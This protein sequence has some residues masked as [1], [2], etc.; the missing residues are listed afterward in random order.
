MKPRLSIHHLSLFLAL[1]IS[2]FLLS[3]LPSNASAAAKETENRKKIKILENTSIKSNGL[4]S[5]LVRTGEKSIVFKGKFE[6]EDPTEKIT[7]NWFSANQKQFKPW[8]K[9]TFKTESPKI[10]K[11][12]ELYINGNFEKLTKALFDKQEGEDLKAEA[13]D[14]SPAESGS[15]G[16]D[17]SADASSSIGSESGSQSQQTPG[18]PATNPAPTTTVDRT[19]SSTATES[20]PHEIAGSQ[21][22]LKTK[23][24]TTFSDGSTEE[25]AC[26]TASTYDLLNTYEGCSPRH[27]FVS[28][29]T[30][31]QQKT[32]YVNDE[33]NFIMTRSCHD[34]GT[35]FVHRKSAASC[36]ETFDKTN[37]LIYQSKKTYYT[38]INA[39]V[40]FISEC[41]M[42]ANDFRSVSPEDYLP[43]YS[44]ADRV[45][46]ASSLA[47]K[48][49]KYYIQLGDKKVYVSD[50]QDDLTSPMP[51]YRDYNNCTYFHDINA[52][53]SSRQYQ[54]VYDRDG[55]K[56]SVSG[57][58]P[59]PN[60]SFAHITDE[61]FCTPDVINRQLYKK[62]S[63]Y[64]LD[65]TGKRVVVADCS[66][67]DEIQT[68]DPAFV[69]KNYS[70]CDP[71]VDLSQMRAV[72]RFVEE[73]SLGTQ[74]KEISTCIADPSVTYPIANSAAGCAYRIDT[75]GGLAVMQERLFFNDGAEDHFV[76]ECRDSAITAP[77]I[78]SSSSCIPQVSG[79]NLVEY[80]ETYYINAN[81]DKK[82][83][84]A[85]SASD[86]L[87]PI[88][89][90]MKTYDY[91]SCTDSIDLTAMKAF[92]RYKT[93]V[94]I[95]GNQTLLKSCTVDSASAYTITQ[96]DV[97]CGIRHDF[98]A[99]VSYVQN[100]LYYTNSSGSD[101]DV[102][103]CFDTPKTYTHYK[104]V[105]NCSP[106]YDRETNV[107][108]DTKKTYFTDDNGNVNHITG[109]LM[110]MSSSKAVLSSDI[111][112][113]YQSEDEVDFE[114]RAAYK[115]YREYIVLSGDKKEYISAV[116]ADKASPMPIEKD[117]GSCDFY[118]DQVGRQSFRQFEEV[119]IRDGV[120]KVVSDC[121]KDNARV[122]AHITDGQYCIPKIQSKIVYTRESTYFLDETSKRIVV[123]ECELNGATETI[124][125]SL[126]EKDYLICAP[127]IDLQAGVAHAA[128]KE[129]VTFDETDK[130]LSDCIEDQQRSYIITE[131]D[132]G[133]TYRVDLGAEKA[134][135]QKRLFYNNGLEDVYLTACRDSA[136]E[137]A[138]VKSTAL[139]SPTITDDGSS[140]N[141][142][143]ET[144]FID[145][146]GVKRTV[147]ECS[148][149]GVSYL[150][151]EDSKTKDF[152]RCEPDI[153]VDEMAAYGRYELF[154]KAGGENV[155]IQDC[156]VDPSVIYA[157]D[158]DYASC[159]VKIDRVSAT[160]IQYKKL[161]YRKGN[162]DVYVSACI[163]SDTA[164]PIQQTV[165]GC[166][167]RI[168]MANLTATA[169]KRDYYDSGGS[170][171]YTTEC[172]DTT[173]ATPILQSAE[174]CPVELSADGL[175]LIEKKESYYINADGHKK[176]V[177]AC[178]PT[179]TVT[180]VPEE[181]KIRNY[182]NCDPI[183]DM[184]NSRANLQYQLY[185]HHGN[186]EI[187]IQGCT[188][189]L[190]TDY[191]LFLDYSEC[192]PR[193]D[194]VNDEV[195]ETAKWY[196]KDGLD[197]VY[198]TKCIESETRYPIESRTDVCEVLAIDNDPD[199]VIQQSRLFY[200][201]SQGQLKYITPC[202]PTGNVLAVTQPVCSDIQTAGSARY[203]HNYPA[204][205][206]YIAVKDMYGEQVIQNCHMSDKHNAMTHYQES[207]GWA[208][209][210][211]RFRS[212]LKVRT[213]ITDALTGAKVY[214]DSCHTS[215]TYVSYAYMGLTNIAGNNGGS[216]TCGAGLYWDGSFPSG[217]YCY[218]YDNGWKYD[219]FA[220]NIDQFNAT[221]S[222]SQ[223]KSGGYVGVFNHYL[224]PD[225]TSYH[226]WKS[227]YCGIRSAEIIAAVPLHLP[228]SPQNPVCGSVTTC[229]EYFCNTIPTS[230]LPPVTNV[231]KDSA[232]LF[233]MDHLGWT[234]SN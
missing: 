67:T 216:T 160:A 53:S 179:G 232:N 121:Q 101:V 159:P 209:D 24:I 212:T 10:F 188:P 189:D 8:F 99:G 185:V 224:R 41:M 64:F 167:Y 28:A 201:D 180:P 9:S 56:K 186:E 82:V 18:A 199:N 70:K 54:L 15:K 34:T 203:I 20:C 65:E 182:A 109:C 227:N 79:K 123:K 136:Y 29:V 49:F 174:F 198:V 152:T 98:S 169:Q 115:R 33:G 72:A 23:T 93:Y 77:L 48:R 111:Q 225:D 204:G 218:V 207:C 58:K 55:V 219:H 88:T 162:E 217:S 52:V 200:S 170:L 150:I 148:E 131:T 106:V 97:G 234:P 229:N 144:Y 119:Y 68:I 183:L 190:E 176:I 177:E 211:A 66:V 195:T 228:V 31:L 25:S 80:Q 85:C 163:A 164:Y 134:V 153:V 86:E 100:R 96:T 171:H 74:V 71:S 178:K 76:S 151:P 105:S 36:D 168:D 194:L 112:K 21:I 140:F 62:V 26:I 75:V 130:Y 69:S 117:Y 35:T 81:G 206:T 187:M 114:A 116:K 205:Q 89:E 12:Q 147:I 120:K 124:N 91:D 13:E 73:V 223:W 47:F 191:D 139:C 181:N 192:D 213:Y 142:R 7:V 220:F 102:K 132:S 78:K 3:L 158:E 38:D 125:P 161:F 4:I 60:M 90:D 14:P 95:M 39:N 184:P 196:Y 30:H 17:G 37:N 107:T 138:F 221:T 155:K 128:Y 230:Q 46:P 94:D 6:L 83:V 122:F 175:F 57:C 32:G 40:H 231:N 173:E 133:C 222:L 61:K 156:T 154:A 143:E 210:D 44:N 127:R 157:I 45:A 11:G 16:S 104:M 51:I 126:I 84:V 118:H 137:F 233:G 63:T 215:N 22:H 19:V 103:S 226:V 59:D 172:Y 1:L 129:K 197:D 141:Q 113:E 87:L 110:D 166:D 5:G 135:Q 108:Y 43:E 165:T 193:I 149:N 202:Q 208:H 146:S 27:D 42:D 50:W 214:L 145:G 2:L 92:R